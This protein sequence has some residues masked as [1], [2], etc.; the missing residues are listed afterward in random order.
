MEDKTVKTRVFPDNEK[1]DAL[2]SNL[3][4]AQEKSLE[5]VNKNAQLEEE[6]RKSL[7]HLQTIGEL[8][9]CLKQE[10]AVTAEMKKKAAGLEARIKELAGLETKVKQLAEL[11]AKVIHTAELEVK[12]KE[13][14]EALSKISIIAATGK[15]G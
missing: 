9:E 11:E 12:V 2:P 7:E 10:Q 14:T 4:E 6:R 13:L 5:L 8:N 15:V 1:S 3:T